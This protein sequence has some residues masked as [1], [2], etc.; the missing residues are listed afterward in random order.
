MRCIELVEMIIGIFKV[1]ATSFRGGFHSGF[2]QGSTIVQP[3][4]VLF[5]RFAE[6]YKFNCII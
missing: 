3:C 5:I 2:S 4:A 6:I 1:L